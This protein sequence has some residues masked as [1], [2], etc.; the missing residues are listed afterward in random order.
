MIYGVS[1]SDIDLSSWFYSGGYFNDACKALNASMKEDG[2]DTR[3]KHA[4]YTHHDST[5]DFTAHDVKSNGPLPCEATR[6]TR[7]DLV[8]HLTEE[9]I[10]RFSKLSLRSIM[11]RSASQISP[12]I[13]PCPADN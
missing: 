12:E 1:R 13:S 2:R 10:R 7:T 3:F 8:S 11:R 5:F 9:C 6:A 4:L